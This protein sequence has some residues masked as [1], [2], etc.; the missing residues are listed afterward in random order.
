MH[1]Y[2]N[3]SISYSVDKCHQLYEKALR[4]N[5]K[6]IDELIASKVCKAGLQSTKII[7]KKSGVGLINKFNHEKIV[8]MTAFDP[9]PHIKQ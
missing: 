1:K 5:M 2:N 3:R 6:D 4:I 9:I 7:N 8:R